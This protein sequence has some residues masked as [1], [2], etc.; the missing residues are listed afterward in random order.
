MP[1]YL[2]YNEISQPN[3]VAQ[4]FPS[5]DVKDFISDP[6]CPTLNIQN[7]TTSDKLLD[8]MLNFT[9]WYFEFSDGEIN[10]ESDFLDVIERK[11]YARNDGVSVDE[12]EYGRIGVDSNGE[13]GIP[14]RGFIIAWSFLPDLF[15]TLGIPDD[16]KLSGYMELYGAANIKELSEVMYKILQKN[17]ISTT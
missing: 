2:M 8:H 12:V 6:D 9:Y 15:E 10:A 1:D 17:V 7:G 4:Y 16:S 14:D 5:L 3:K 11:A 13:G